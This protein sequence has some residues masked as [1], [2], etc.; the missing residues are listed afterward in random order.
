MKRALSDG[1]DAADSDLDESIMMTEEL[2]ALEQAL[3]RVKTEK[4]LVE[5]AIP[6]MRALIA[7]TAADLSQ[8]NRQLVPL[9]HKFLELMARGEKLMDKRS[10]GSIAIHQLKGALIDLKS[11]VPA[12]IEV[13]REKMRVLWEK[14][15]AQALS[16]LAEKGYSIG[17]RFGSDFYDVNDDELAMDDGTW[18]CFDCALTPGEK[19][20]DE[21][22]PVFVLGKSQVVKSVEKYFVHGVIDP[23]LWVYGD[24]RGAHDSIQRVHLNMLAFMHIVCF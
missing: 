20:Y 16:Q 4:S 7:Q 21:M 13:E 10:N 9:T 23:M 8:H 18:V 6:T 11:G 22:T 19:S 14:V 3:V 12:Q 15:K 1:A 17:Q 24:R 5:K 2:R